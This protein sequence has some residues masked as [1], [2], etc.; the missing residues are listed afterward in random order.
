M[1]TPGEQQSGALREVEWTHTDG[2]RTVR[3][4]EPDTT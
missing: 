4:V 3:P 1:T 2:T